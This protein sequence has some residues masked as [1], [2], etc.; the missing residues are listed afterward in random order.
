MV[1][2]KRM[3]VECYECKHKREVPGNCHIRCAKP[4]PSMTGNPHG[5]KHGWF[6]YPYLFDPVWK[7][8]LCANFEERG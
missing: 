7:T 4:D 5:I 1:E 8:S 3:A 2:K 6:Y